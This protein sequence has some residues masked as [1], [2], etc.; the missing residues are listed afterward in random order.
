MLNVLYRYIL[1]TPL[2][3]GSTTG[4]T[5]AAKFLLWVVGP[6]NLADHSESHIE[7]T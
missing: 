6:L 4:S 1:Y 3:T 5:G 7:S 2:D